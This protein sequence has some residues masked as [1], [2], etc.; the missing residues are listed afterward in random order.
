MDNVYGQ[1]PG[2]GHRTSEV[3][4]VLAASFRYLRSQLSSRLIFS[5][6]KK[7]TTMLFILMSRLFDTA[8]NVE[9][10]LHVSNALHGSQGRVP[11]LVLL[12]FKSKEGI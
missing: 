2:H 12:C 5:S 1:A 10:P 11:L 4:G 7:E 9:K 3:K 8:A 6:L